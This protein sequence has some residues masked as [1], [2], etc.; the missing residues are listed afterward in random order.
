MTADTIHALCCPFHSTLDNKPIH[1][2]HIHVAA[3]IS[4][5]LERKNTSNAAVSTKN[6]MCNI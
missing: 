6:V 3:E 1:V 4:I 2:L 5:L